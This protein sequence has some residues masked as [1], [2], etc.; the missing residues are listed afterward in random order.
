MSS[1]AGGALAIGAIMQRI[2]LSPSEKRRDAWD[3]CVG[4]IWDC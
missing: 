2:S 1:G 4:Y 3:R